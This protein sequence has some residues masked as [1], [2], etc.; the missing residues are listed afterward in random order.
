M[1]FLYPIIIALF[2]LPNFAF[3]SISI[4]E[5]M[6]DLDG[7]DTDREWVEIF[8]DGN[9]V[10]LTGWKFNDGSNHILN[11]PPKNGGVGSMTIPSN[12]YIVLTEDANVFLN[13]HTGYSGAVVD[14]VMSLGNTEGILYLVDPDGGTVGSVTYSKT[15]GANDDGNSLQKVG[16]NFISAFC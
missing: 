4:T 10:D 14:T 8:N 2:L 11:V 12:G 5:I 9:P 3:A 1:K 16:N 7:S 6:Y 13:E 15:M